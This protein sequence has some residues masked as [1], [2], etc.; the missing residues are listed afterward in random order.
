M[1]PT[2]TCKQRT[3]S[4]VVLEGSSLVVEDTGFVVKN[5]IVEVAI[6]ERYWRMS[7]IFGSAI[8]LDIS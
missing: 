3:Y 8:L 6:P 7:I 5:G 2:K 1:S 4:K